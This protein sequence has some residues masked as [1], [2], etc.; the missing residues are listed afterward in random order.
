MTQT[1]TKI[2]IIAVF[3][4]VIIFDIVMYTNKVPGDT[5]SEVIW[6]TIKT[7]PWIAFMAGFICGHLF[8]QSS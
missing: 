7:A 8:W 2:V 5:I 4:G 1:I 6:M 3:L